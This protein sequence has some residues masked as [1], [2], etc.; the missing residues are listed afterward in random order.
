M[1]TSGAVEAT[2]PDWATDL[3]DETRRHAADELYG[4]GCAAAMGGCLWIGMALAVLGLLA[5][6]VLYGY[7][8]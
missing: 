8:A 3:E 7:V 6:V 4:S 1:G 2:D 5:L